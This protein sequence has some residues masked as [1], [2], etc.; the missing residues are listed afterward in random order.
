[1]PEMLLV[2]GFVPVAVPFGQLL[3]VSPGPA[4][5]S[6]AFIRVGHDEYREFGQYE[7]D[8]QITQN[9]QRRAI[10]REVLARPDGNR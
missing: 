6:K 4:A 3:F 5:R 1:M 10:E 2:V 8:Q 7:S 9:L